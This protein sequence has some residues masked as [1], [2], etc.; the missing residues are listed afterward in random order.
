MPITLP[1]VHLNGS[2][3]HKLLEDNRIAQRSVETAIDALC[4]AAPHGRDY[5]V[6]GPEA[7]TEARREHDKR[8]E[9]LR[10]VLA[11]LREIGRSLDEQVEF[12]FKRD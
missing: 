6:K 3:G 7:Y 10:A 2:S 12:R 1:V 9:S 4:N 5:Y 8:V 11:E